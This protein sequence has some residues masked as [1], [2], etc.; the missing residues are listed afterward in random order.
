MAAE[1]GFEDVAELAAQS[2]GQGAAAAPPKEQRWTN[3]GGQRHNGEIGSVRVGTT[4][5]GL[6]KMPS[7]AGR[8]NL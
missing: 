6:D 4:V 2:E 5:H 1:E 3:R 8:I 7:D